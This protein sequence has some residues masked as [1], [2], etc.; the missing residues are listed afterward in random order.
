MQTEPKQKPKQQLPILPPD[1][2]VPDIITMPD[3]KEKEMV[4]YCEDREEGEIMT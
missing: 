2:T 3:M 4:K 1:F